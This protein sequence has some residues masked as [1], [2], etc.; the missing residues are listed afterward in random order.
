MEE[1]EDEYNDYILEIASRLSKA[2]FSKRAENIYNSIEKKVPY[3]TPI[4]LEQAKHY[5]RIGNDSLSRKYYK[6]Y[7]NQIMK[8]REEYGNL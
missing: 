7:N 2:G 8:N 3:Y 4:Y 5:K 1:M 6:K